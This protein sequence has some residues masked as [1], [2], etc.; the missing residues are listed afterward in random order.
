MEKGY[1]KNKL[2]DL[3][4]RIPDFFEPNELAYY[5]AHCKNEQQ[6]RD[7]I[8]WE[9][10]KDIAQKYGNEYVVRREWAPKDKK[11]SKNR[12]DLAILKLEFKTE[13]KDN[14]EE[15]RVENIEKVIA[16]IEF[17]AHSIARPEPSFYCS[18]FMRDVEKMLD[19]KEGVTPCND[20]DLFFVFLETGQSR[21]AQEY[22]SVLGFSQ[23]Q[24][25]KC[26]YC[27]GT[28]D[29]V[30]LDAIKSHWDA[31]KN[32]EG[33]DKDNKVKELLPETI[34]YPEAIKIGE[35][36]GYTQ[37]FSPL[38]IGPLKYAREKK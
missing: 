19:L 9:L 4:N 36:F 22:Q 7:R 35:V 29:R 37:Y 18:E 27:K 13:K 24:N 12:V 30:Y 6:I 15:K 23:Y 28:E 32:W 2:Q 33:F 1:I 17:K 10:H 11:F 5:S 14:N 26:A 25:S 38:V 8:A 21:K 16:L 3:L 34:P 31:F 20:A